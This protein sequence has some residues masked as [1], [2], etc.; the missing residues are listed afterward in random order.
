MI[1]L[2]GGQNKIY[3]IIFH[4]PEYYV[5]S[6]SKKG[7]ELMNVSINKGFELMSVSNKWS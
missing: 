5:M 4:L 2:G 7:L 1:H 3:P 6:V